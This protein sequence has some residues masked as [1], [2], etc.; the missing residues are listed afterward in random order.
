MDLAT[1]LA[2]ATDDTLKIL[3]QMQLDN[4]DKGG[5]LDTL[6]AELATR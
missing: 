3:V 5:H 6:L 2:Q 1:A 4:G